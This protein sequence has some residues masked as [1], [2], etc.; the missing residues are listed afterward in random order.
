MVNT[1]IEEEIAEE[2]RNIAFYEEKELAEQEKR[3]KQL[4]L[5][6]LFGHPH[7]QVLA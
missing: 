6:E 2:E 5:E 7:L 4:D 3:R 1:Q